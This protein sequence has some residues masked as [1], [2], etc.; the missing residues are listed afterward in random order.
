MKY[1]QF[2]KRFA[3]TTNTTP[4]EAHETLRIAADLIGSAI[5]NNGGLHIP[6]VGKFKTVTRKARKGRNPATGETIDIAEHRV[7]TFHPAAA[8]KGALKEPPPEEA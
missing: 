3:H 6:E 5:V 1:E 4:K 8:L 7:V 2:V